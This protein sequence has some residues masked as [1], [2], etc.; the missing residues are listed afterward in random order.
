MIPRNRLIYCRYLETEDTLPGGKI[1]LLDG[2]KRAIT[3]Q[4]GRIVAAAAGG[5]DADG[6]WQPTDPR[7]C[8]GAW[9]LHAAFK[10]QPAREPDHFWVHEDDVLA[11]LG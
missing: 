4:Q 8:E 1:V 3:S 5:Y 11:V 9:I 6:V 7:L 2:S 10:R